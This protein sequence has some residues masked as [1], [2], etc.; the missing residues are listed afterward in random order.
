MLDNLLRQKQYNIKIFFLILILDRIKKFSTKITCPI[1][2]NDTA[3]L[4]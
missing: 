2:E 3:D 4:V 1:F